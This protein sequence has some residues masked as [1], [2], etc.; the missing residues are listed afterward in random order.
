MGEAKTSISMASQILLVGQQKMWN[1]FS[2][3]GTKRV[4][5]ADEQWNRRG[6]GEDAF[7]RGHRVLAAKKEFVADGEESFLPAQRQAHDGA[8]Q[9]NSYHYHWPGPAEEGKNDR[10]V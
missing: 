4:H 1:G 10:S 7:F 2:G 5:G 3:H 9:A 8:Q 6:G